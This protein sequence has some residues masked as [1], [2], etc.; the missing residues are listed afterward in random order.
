M[1]NLWYSRIWAAQRRRV[2]LV[3]GELSGG[4]ESGHAANVKNGPDDSGT[5]PTY[6]GRSLPS[7]SCAPPAQSSHLQVLDAMIA[8]CDGSPSIR[9]HL[10]RERTAL[11]AE[12]LARANA[13]IGYGG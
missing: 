1:R 11:S 4:V 2:D 3:G 6:A 8:R 13:W 7:G 9:E 10:L 5:G 12:E